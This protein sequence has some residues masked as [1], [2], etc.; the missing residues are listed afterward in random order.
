[1][2]QVAPQQQAPQAPPPVTA[3]VRAKAE[4]N[5]RKAKVQLVVHQPFFASIILKRKITMKDDVPTAF[6][7]AKGHITVGTGWFSELTVQQSMGL[8]AH[9]ALHYALLH[10]IRV[11]W[12][13][14]RPANSAMDK[15]INDILKEAGMELPPNGTFMDGARDYAW[16]QLYDDTEEDGNGPGKGP[17]QPGTGNDDLSGE[18]ADDVI[19]EQIEEI[20]QEL[21]QAATAAKSRGTMPAG[22]EQLIKDIIDPATPW[23]TLLERYMLLQI[24]AGRS[25]KR[26]NKKYLAHDLYMPSTG[27]EAAM[28]TVVIQIDE[29]GSVPDS[30]FP[31]FSGHMNKIIELCHPEKVIVL[32]TDSRV[33]FVEEF[34]AEDY[35]IT[36]TTHARGGTDMTQGF[37]WVEE[38][39]I[40][41]DVFITLTDGET[42]W[43]DSPV[44]YPNVVLSTTKGIE[45]PHAENIYY[46]L[47]G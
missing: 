2:T 42:P 35:P 44:G 3:A 33:A 28:G 15:V 24:K 19:S 40:E 16:E 10:H 43:I 11:G 31:H 26:P 21:I 6:V 23:H 1:M 14:P 36:F 22:M 17:Y 8:L 38:N 12:R 46:E 7:N 25:W 34:S 41:P 27:T 47:E 30:T 13:K 5:L 4:D 18:G 20:K 37:N 9:E 32:H 39:G 45:L 29:S